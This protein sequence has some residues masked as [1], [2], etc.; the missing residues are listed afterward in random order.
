M[1]NP[2]VGKSLHGLSVYHVSPLNHQTCSF[3][4]QVKSQEREDEDDDEE[5]EGEHVEGDDDGDSV[6][7]E[8][9]S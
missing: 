1:Y 6:N 5:E 3:K 2:K 8:D 9:D 7:G 4:P